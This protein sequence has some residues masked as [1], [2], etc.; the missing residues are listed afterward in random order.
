LITNIN[1]CVGSN[2]IK[3]AKLIQGAK[4]N[5]V[6]AFHA[7]KPDAIVGGCSDFFCGNSLS[8]TEHARI[9]EEQETGGR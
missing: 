7:V 9:A 2:P 4:D 5:G 6:A 1:Q 8:R 3:G